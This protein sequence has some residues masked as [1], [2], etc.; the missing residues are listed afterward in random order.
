MAVIILKCGCYTRNGFAD[1]CLS[2]NIYSAAAGEKSKESQ[3]DAFI[4]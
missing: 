2:L 1:V 3:G 4:I